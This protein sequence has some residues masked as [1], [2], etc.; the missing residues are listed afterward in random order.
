MQVLS[1]TRFNFWFSAEH[2]HKSVFKPGCDPDD[3]SL[4]ASAE[5]LRIGT[6]VARAHDEP[7]GMALDHAIQYFRSAECPHQKL[8]LVALDFADLPATFLH[9]IGQLV[10]RPGKQQFALIE[11][12]HFSAELG[13]IEIR[14]APHHG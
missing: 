13:F 9:P 12:Q 10:R 2:I 4:C 6:S 5:R 1:Q 11:Q 8:T 7:N 14:G 3:L